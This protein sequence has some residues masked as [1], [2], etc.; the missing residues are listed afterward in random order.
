VDSLEQVFV[1]PI[2][3]SQGHNKHLALYFVRDRNKNVTS[4]FWFLNPISV[5]RLVFLQR[6]VGGQ[7]ELK[8]CLKV[9]YNGRW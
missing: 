1:G 2:S 4:C 6:F 3:P 5:D 7:V 8:L 9:C